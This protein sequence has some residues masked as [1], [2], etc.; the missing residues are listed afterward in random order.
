[1]DKVLLS[2]GW[3]GFDTES[4]GPELTHQK[5][6][7]V[8]RSQLTGFS[9]AFA[10]GTSYYVP[11]N[12]AKGNA[13]F[14]E[15]M[16]LLRV[17]VEDGMCAVHN[18][19]HERRVLSMEG[20]EERWTNAICTQVLCWMLQVS[21]G[22]YGLK[23]LASSLLGFDMKTFEET[24]GGLPFNALDTKDAVD[25][26]CQDA[27]AALLLAQRYYPL[28]YPELDRF[29]G[30]KPAFWNR[31][32]PYIEV[33]Q[34]MEDSGMLLD[35]D[36]LREV[37]SDFRSRAK[38]VLSQWQAVCREHGLLRWEVDDNCLDLE[39]AIS[40]TSSKQLQLL[41]QTGHWAAEGVPYK[42]TGYSTSAE[43]VRMQI[44][45]LPSSEVGKQL[46]EL[47]LE[48]SKLNKL[49]TTYGE[50]L[51]EIASQYPDGRLHC[52][53][54]HTGT[55]TGRLSSSGPNL[56]NIPARTEEGL[57]IRDAFVAPEG[58]SLVSADYSQIEL[59]VLAH[60]CGE[61][62]LFEGYCQGADVHQAVADQLGVTRSQGKTTNFAS[63]YGVGPKK[64]SRSL[65]MT[66]DECKAFLDRYKKEF[67]PEVFALLE[68]AAAVAERRGYVRTL[69][70]RIRRSKLKEAREYLDGL[71]SS[72]NASEEARREAWGRMASEERKAG[73]T[74]I[75]G[76]ARD[77]M[78]EGT[79][80]FY[81]RMDR[82]RCK[83]IAQ[84][85]DD[86]VC[87]VRDDYVEECSRLLKE[88][89]EGAWELRVP[90]VVEPVVGKR[91]SDLK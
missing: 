80:R 79:L 68:K 35:C 15:A 11:V 33:L 66:L 5:F 31:E 20:L 21:E 22:G 34:H 25:Y 87:E 38:S 49:V 27:E 54:L 19:K 90:L 8:Y 86:L 13:A 61:G 46:A 9:L 81:R 57:R 29:R 63:V 43:Y 14:Q 10:D 44:D 58:W 60:F 4:H 3:V 74:P 24:T 30:M 36:K 16:G 83:I 53:Y 73:N 26:A 82:E 56:Q 76:G 85:H 72:H 18:L 91:W 45:S 23:H 2:E 17:L 40:P 51:I 50:K 69:G 59:R 64:L 65:G 48:H 89:L 62:A 7:N 12:H 71:R 32:M 78:V 6:I 41:F 70:G 37:V 47:K 1:M 55:A 75:Q 67:A 88:S 77:V 42:A 39:E 52:N 28:Q 84:I